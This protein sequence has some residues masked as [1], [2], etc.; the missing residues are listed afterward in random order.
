MKRFT[1]A[2]MASVLV[3]VLALTGCIEPPANVQPQTGST[4]AA[5]AEQK[6]VVVQH[7]LSRVADA[8][9]VTPEML[10][11]IKV[12]ETTTAEL[13]DLLG[14]IKPF[15]LG[16]GK[17]IYRYDVGKFIFGADGKLLR[18]HVNH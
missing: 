10:A 3:P 17:Q 13:V 18:Q 1:T 8:K 14:E 11:T 12:G 4:S 2:V 5:G 9:A 15:T 16:D 6:Q 7:D